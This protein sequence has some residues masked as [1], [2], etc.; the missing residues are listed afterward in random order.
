MAK[1]SRDCACR[2]QKHWLAF[3]AYRILPL[4]LWT[5][6]GMRVLQQARWLLVL[7]SAV[8]G[9]CSLLGGLSEQRL[10]GVWYG[11]TA[12][13]DGYEWQLVE[14]RAD[15]RK[16]GLAVT[17]RAGTGHTPLV[18]ESQWWLGDGVIELRAIRASGSGVPAG[19]RITDSVESFGG[20]K[21][22][23]RMTSPVASPV[24]ET[25]YAVKAVPAPR[26]CDFVS[27]YSAQRDMGAAPA[28]IA[29]VE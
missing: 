10:S 4:F 23:T 26:V 5:G 19:Q 3:L 1:V 16:C 7:A 8:L 18:Y 22:V 27:R 14:Y 24:A 20:G 25:F 17:Q 13:T 6:S 15:G 2:Q 29:P 11:V 9:G 12:D 28:A 21:M